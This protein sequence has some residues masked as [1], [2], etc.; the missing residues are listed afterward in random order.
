VGI[1]TL[2]KTHD[3][4]LST[5]IS[6][7]KLTDPLTRHHS[8]RPIPASHI[9]GSQRINFILTTPGLFPAAQTSGSLSQHTLFRSDHRTYFFDFDAQILFSDRTYK[10]QP[11]PSR[12]LRLND[13][14]LVDHYRLKLHEQLTYHKVNEKLAVLQDHADN[15]TWTSEHTECYQTLD[16]VIT[17]AMKYAESQTGKSFSTLHEW[18]PT[19]TCAVQ[20]HRYRTLW[21]Q[22][23]RYNTLP[24]CQLEFHRKATNL[25]DPQ[26]DLSEKDIIHN[27]QQARISL[28]NFQ[29][30]HKELRTSHLEQLAAAIVVSRIPAV[31]LDQENPIY[32]DKISQQILQLIRREN[33]RRSYRKLGRLLRSNQTKGLEKIDVPDTTFLKGKQ[34]IDPKTWTGPWKTITNPQEIAKVVKNMNQLQYNQAH[35]TPFGSGPLAEAM[36]PLGDTTAAE[37]LLKGNYVPATNLLP[38][39]KTI[40]NS[41]SCQYPQVVLTSQNITVGEFSSCYKVAKESTSSSPSGRHIGH[42]KASLQDPILASMHAIMMSIPFQ[43]G[44]VPDRWRRVTDIMLEKTPGDL[45]CHCLQIIALFESDLNHAKRILIGR[46]LSHHLEDNELLTDMQFGSRAGRCCLSAVLK[47]LLS[48][49]HVRIMK[50]TAAFIENDAMRCYDRLMND[51]L[52]LVLKK[53]GVSHTATKCL[54]ELWDTAIHLI[55][56]VYGTSDITYCSTSEKPLYCPGQGSMCGPLFWLLTYW[57]IVSSLDPTIPA[58]TFVSAC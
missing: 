23:T 19:L 17:E 56:T 42:Y 16:K 13:P 29:R 22:S 46:K 15:N 37:A 49:E 55:K 41:V 34:H 14:R 1:P 57:L 35:D 20:A 58:I 50:T 28:K 39:T 38:E 40:L 51:L 53:L 30:Q 24:S 6:T 3:G 47:K 18:S 31:P 48:H 36:G 11:I 26:P 2:D 27:L 21:L 7:C 4:K 45:R 5:L 12:R 9:R 44:I 33:M 25:K 43:V 10:I 32:K 52:L 8:S 54:G